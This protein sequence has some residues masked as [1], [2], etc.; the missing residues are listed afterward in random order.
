MSNLNEC[1]L[2]I[3]YKPIPQIIDC[4]GL[5]AELISKQMNLSEWS[6]TDNRID[7]FDIQNKER[8]FIGFQNAGFVINDSPS[9]KY[10][11]DKTAN[12]IKCLFSQKEFEE[13]LSIYRLGVRLKVCR[14][15]KGSFEELK[16]KYISKYISYG[17]EINKIYDNS[18]PSYIFTSIN[19]RSHSNNYNTRS[20]PMTNAHLI[21]FFDRKIILPKVGLYFDI[22]NWIRPKS[23]IN[24]SQIIK[25]IAGFIQLN[26]KKFEAVTDLILKK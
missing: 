16:Q 14:E 15:Y 23:D 6:I 19:F 2:E 12:L 5:W 7:I 17:D 8:A 18:E 10:F 1:I 3:K 26:W 20:A 25:E 4:R 21:N 24:E 13:N 11:S 9:E 22:D